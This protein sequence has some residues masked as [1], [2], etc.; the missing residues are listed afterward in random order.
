MLS[1]T[2]KIQKFQVSTRIRLK[3]PLEFMLFDHIFL[4]STRIHPKSPLEFTFCKCPLEFT[5]FE[6]WCL[7]E[8]TFRK[9]VLSPSY[10]LF[11]LL[12]QSGNILLQKLRNHQSHSGSYISSLILLLNKVASFFVWNIWKI[13][14]FFTK[15]SFLFLLS[16]CQIPD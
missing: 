13:L 2:C 15:A 4:L 5:I 1:N 9:T 6:K 12:I 3:W 14:P 8:L 16:L 11:L 10:A 7:L